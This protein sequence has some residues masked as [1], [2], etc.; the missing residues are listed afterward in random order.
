MHLIH[1]VNL[2]FSETVEKSVFFLISIYLFTSQ[3]TGV[4]GTH[5][6]LVVSPVEVGSA[7]G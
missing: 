7:Q 6:P 2:H 5:G 3:V 4:A 1:R